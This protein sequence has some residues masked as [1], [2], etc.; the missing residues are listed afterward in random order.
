VVG[1]WTAN[2]Y[3]NDPEMFAATIIEHDGVLQSFARGEAGEAEKRVKAHV[4]NMLARG[5]QASR[6][7]QQDNF[8]VTENG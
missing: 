2:A 6:F 3:R 1:L 5:L 7:D 8:L 4:E